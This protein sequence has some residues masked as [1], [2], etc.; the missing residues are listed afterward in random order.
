ML[1]V[2]CK[3]KWWRLWSLRWAGAK[4]TLLALA[5]A[6]PSTILDFMR[7]LSPSMRVIIIAVAFALLVGL[8]CVFRL[9]HQKKVSGH[10]P[11]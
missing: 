2:D 4:S 10:A 6:N 3:R 7:E 1:I 11:A 9:T 5:L 8:D